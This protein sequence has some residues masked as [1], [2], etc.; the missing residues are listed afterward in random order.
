M[1]IFSVVK[2][3]EFIWLFV[4]VFQTCPNTRRSIQ[5]HST[6]TSRIGNS[7]KEPN[8]KEYLTDLTEYSSSPGYKAG[9]E[10]L[11]SEKQMR[12]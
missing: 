10:L 3:R 5:T 6:S 11:S 4:L 8:K 7:L 12:S 2:S 1:I 9:F